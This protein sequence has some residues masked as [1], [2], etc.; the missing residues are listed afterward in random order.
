MPRADSRAK[1]TSRFAS[2]LFGSPGWRNA[3]CFW[4]MQGL[5]M[6]LGKVQIKDLISALPHFNKIMFFPLLEAFFL[7]AFKNVFPLFFFSLPLPLSLWL[8]AHPR[9]T[10]SCSAG[11]YPKWVP[12]SLFFWC[13]SLKGGYNPFISGWLSVLWP[14]AR[15]SQV[16][17]VVNSAWGLDTWTCAGEVQTCSVC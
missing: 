16:D 8:S 2:T 15:L 14:V 3:P 9:V 13:Y 4:Q 5:Q 12:S 7:G 10:G 6:V 17:K 1:A 11:C